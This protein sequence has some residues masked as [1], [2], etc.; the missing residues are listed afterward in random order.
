MARI[1]DAMLLPGPSD[2]CLKCRERGGPGM[3]DIPG[4]LTEL[5]YEHCR[6]ISKQIEA[7]TVAEKSNAKS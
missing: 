6:E 4:P 5:S 7:K 3:S 2:E 1:A